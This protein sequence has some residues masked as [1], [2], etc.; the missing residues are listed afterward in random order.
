[1]SEEE[2]RRAVRGSQG[3][4]WEPYFFCA[5][6][7]LTARRREGVSEFALARAVVV[8]SELVL[9]NLAA[10]RVAMDAEDLRSAGLIAVGPLQDALDKALFEFSDSFIEQNPTLYH[11]GD[12][13]FQLIF[14]DRT[15]RTIPSSRVFR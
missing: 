4:A 1:L 6:E 5:K 14:H 10:Q 15:L 2:Q 3:A 7:I 13:S 12:Q 9:V 8:G 11:L